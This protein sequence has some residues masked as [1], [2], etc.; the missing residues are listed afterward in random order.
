M[1]VC[2]RYEGFDQR[3]YDILQP[4]EISLGDYVLNGGEVA[5]MV[6]IDALVRLIIAPA[7]RAARKRHIV[8]MRLDRRHGAAEIAGR[9]P[10]RQFGDDRFGRL[11]G[12]VT[13]AHHDPTHVVEY[14]RAVL[15]DTG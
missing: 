10:V 12:R 6:L 7:V 4:E 1:L 3:V 14:D 5:A 15:I 8:A 9:D 2:G 13:L 11:G